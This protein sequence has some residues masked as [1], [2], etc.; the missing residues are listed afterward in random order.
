MG[1]DTS[2]RFLVVSSD[3][4]LEDEFDA[5]LASIKGFR[6]VA[7]YARDERSGIEGARL[8]L[9]D[10][11]VV[12][13]AGRLEDV[14]AFAE[15]VGVCAPD[16][17]IVAVYRRQMFDDADAETNAIIQVLRA[18]V[19][20][21]LRR[22]ISVGEVPQTIDR[23]FRQPARTMGPVGRVVSFVSNKGG[24]GKST[25]S[26][27]VA[28]ELA[29]RHPGRVL[30]IDASLQLGI[31]AS[32]LDL[33]PAQTVTDAAQQLDRLDTTLLE[34]LTVQHESGLRVLAAPPTMLA[35]A[36]VDERVISRVIALARRSYEYVVIDTFPALD[37]VL[38]SIL[39]LS[40]IVCVVT[41]VVVPVLNGTASL[42][43][44]LREL[45]LDEQRIWVLLNRGQPRFAAQLRPEDIEDH[46]GIRLRHQIGYDKRVPSAVNLGRPLVLATSRFSAFRRAI[47]GVVDDIVAHAPSAPS[48]PAPRSE[49]DGDA[50]EDDADR[51]GLN[52]RERARVAA[53]VL[54]EA[55]V[56]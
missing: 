43:E 19:Q 44:T 39:D 22:P 50:P 46:L 37:G 32:A 54:E 4:H 24:V 29:S 56:R 49:A 13:L 14:R 30:L 27:N 47:A 20:D 38:M 10:V 42:L 45:G 35:A 18:R 31:C 55:R 8:H 6:C 15:E 40:N 17:A 23:L 25:V 26:T 34:Q 21:F 16:A 48:E 9:P 33:E 1:R 53:P 11:V 51:P 41:Q 36:D 28:C 2:V 3:P 5:A 12:E 52:G 7:T